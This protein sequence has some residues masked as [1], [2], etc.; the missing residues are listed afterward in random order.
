MSPTISVIKIFMAYNYIKID[1]I[2]FVMRE[3]NTKTVLKHHLS[4]V[5]MTITKKTNNK[6]WQG[7]GERENFLNLLHKLM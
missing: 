2:S 5:R 6:F 3:I 4:S 1:S 7:Y